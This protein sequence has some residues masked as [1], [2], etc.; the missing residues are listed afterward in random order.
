MKYILAGIECYKYDKYN[1][2]GMVS[3]YYINTKN[4]RWIY[5]NCIYFFLIIQDDSVYNC[6]EIIKM[7]Y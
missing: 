4:S 5:G 2:Y 3:Q 1:K 6:I 7:E